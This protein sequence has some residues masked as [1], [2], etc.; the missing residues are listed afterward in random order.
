MDC[1]IKTLPPEAVYPLLVGSVQPRPIAWVSTQDLLGV[2]NLAPFSFFT[3]A[4][5]KPPVLALSILTPAGGGEKD[6]LA[7]IR[8]TGEFVVN[9]VPE[10]LA[11]AMNLS[12]GPYAP[13][14]DEFDLAGV[15]KAR[16]RQVRAPGVEQAPLRF[17][18]VLNQCLALGDGAGAGNLV[19]G[20]VRHVHV[21][22]EAWRDGRVA[23]KALALVGKLGGDEFSRAEAAFS[24]RRPGA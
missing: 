22:D 1:D 15:G 16:S 6:T 24:L 13:E 21:A 8:A 11:E 14:V 17:E 12:C 9:V 2:A 19:L 5:V 7:N 10:H 18:C 23:S 3:V 20:E 4:S